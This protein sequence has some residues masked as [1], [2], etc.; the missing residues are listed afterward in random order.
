M[1]GQRVN[2][3]IPNVVCRQDCAVA[4][5]GQLRVKRGGRTRRERQCDKG[6]NNDLLKV[7]KCVSL[8]KQRFRVETAVTASL[9]SED[10]VDTQVPRVRR[11]GHAGIKQTRSDAN[12][13]CVH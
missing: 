4:D 6:T 10:C 3:R 1:H 12:A 13:K 9:H 7:K 2:P 8:W 5:L 11:R